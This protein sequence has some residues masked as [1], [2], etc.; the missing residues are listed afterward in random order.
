MQAVHDKAH[1]PI[2]GITQISNP[3]A[4]LA[5]SLPGS[6]VTITPQT[7]AA[8]GGV[9]TASVNGEATPATSIAMGIPTVGTTTVLPTALPCAAANHTLQAIQPVGTTVNA[10]NA[11]SILHLTT[12]LPLPPHLQQLQNGQ[13]QVLH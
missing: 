2:P 6:G 7:V 12:P 11:S 13:A 8:C 1:A 10:V 5:A 9:A 4:T 3:V